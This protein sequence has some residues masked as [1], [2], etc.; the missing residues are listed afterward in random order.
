M[1]NTNNDLHKVIFIDPFENDHLK[2]WFHNFILENDQEAFRLLYMNMHKVLN[3]STVNVTKYYTKKF[4]GKKLSRLA[5]RLKPIYGEKVPFFYILL[6]IRKMFLEE[7]SQISVYAPCID[8]L[9]GPSLTFKYDLSYPFFLY[10]EDFKSK[11]NGHSQ[12]P[13]SEEQLTN[14]L[15]KFDMKGRVAKIRKQEI[16]Y[17]FL[18]ARDYQDWYWNYI[19]LKITELLEEEKSDNYFKTIFLDDPDLHLKDETLQ[20]IDDIVDDDDQYNILLN[21]VKMI[22]SKKEYEL[23]MLDFSYFNE[24]STDELSQILKVESES[25]YRYRTRY[26]KK[27]A[28]LNY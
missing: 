23:F 3:R 27:L 21:K 26:K 19:H 13:L 18:I 8:D 28:T 15:H 2:M 1:N 12:L 22:L 16:N 10:L 11:N 14:K 6:R 17:K 25:I 7:F 9:Y 24:K 4:G 20:Y 5:R